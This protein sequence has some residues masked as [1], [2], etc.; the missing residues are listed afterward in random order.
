MCGRGARLLGRRSSAHE[1]KCF[2]LRRRQ[3]LELGKRQNGDDQARQHDH[4][5]RWTFGA[6]VLLYDDKSVAVLRVSDVGIATL[7]PSVRVHRHAGGQHDEHESKTCHLGS[8]Y[9]PLGIH[10]HI[11][12]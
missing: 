7:V 6:H 9:S 4:R 2:L 8:A 1:P 11:V 3:R 12:S 5:R 10:A